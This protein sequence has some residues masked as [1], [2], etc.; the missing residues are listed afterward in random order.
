MFTFLL[1]RDA[2]L[3]FI[4]PMKSSVLALEK[5]TSGALISRLPPANEIKDDSVLAVFGYHDPR[6]REM[7]WEL[8]YRGNRKIAKLLGEILYDVICAEV[9]ER[10]LFLNF[11]SERPILLVPMPTSSQRRNE[12]GYNQT[13]LLTQAIHVCDAEKRFET[14]NT[15]LIKSEYSKSQTKTTSKRD[16]LHNIESTMRVLDTISLSDRI[17]ILIDDVTT[18]GA[19][20]TEAKRALKGA[21]AKKILCIAV[22]H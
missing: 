22:A 9:A 1:V 2:F 15:I 19:T 8:K 20:F 18:T 7:I 17:I 21:G 6:V 13:E 10:A 3:E 14:E 12:R 4:F 16:R 5:E 11:T